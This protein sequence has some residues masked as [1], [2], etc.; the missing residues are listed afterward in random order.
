MPHHPGAVYLLSDGRTAR[1]SQAVCYHHRARHA[2]TGALAGTGRDD[3]IWAEVPAADP[4]DALRLRV[5]AWLCPRGE[6]L[7]YADRALHRFRD[8]VC[9][10]YSEAVFARYR[11]LDDGVVRDEIAIE[12]DE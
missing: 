2:A 11:R 4:T 3:G 12:D 1:D 5:V 9:G 10:R 8:A 6:A 7:L